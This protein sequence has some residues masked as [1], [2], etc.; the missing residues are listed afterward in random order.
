MMGH[1]YYDEKQY[2]KSIACFRRAAQMRNDEGAY[3]C[4]V[5]IGICYKVLKR[6]N[7]AIEMFLKALQRLI[8][9]SNEYSNDAA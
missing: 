3:E 9:S 4:Y 6:N 5:N 8:A 1:Y 7:K 2:V